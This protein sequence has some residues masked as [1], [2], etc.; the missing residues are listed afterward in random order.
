[1]QLH[2]YGQGAGLPILCLHG[3]PGSGRTMAVF[4]DPL[5]RQYRTLAPDLRGYGASQTKVPYRLE[6]HLEDLLALLDQQGIER[7]VILG[8]SLGGILAMEMALRYPHRVMGLILVATAARPISNHPP[9]PWWELA[10]T[11]IASILNLLLPGHPWVINTFG[12]RSLYRYLLQRHTPAA[13]HRLAQEGFWAYVQTSRQANQA[14]NRALANRY[15]RLPDLEQIR[16]PC[17]ML[18]G[19]EDR[20]ITAQASLETAQHLPFAESYCFDQTAHLLPWEISD[21]LLNK[22]EA[23]LERHACYFTNAESQTEI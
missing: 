3:H 6:D 5:A 23:W 10:N 21:E 2:F 1:M 4:C 17:L 18:C 16:C 19:A 11:G 8:W 20:H 22:I 9:V 7:C 15:N 14:L 12:K 13:Y